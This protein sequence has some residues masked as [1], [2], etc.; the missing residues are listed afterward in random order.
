MVLSCTKKEPIYGNQP[1]S[2]AYFSIWGEGVS[3]PQA[4]K[5]LSPQVNPY[6][7]SFLPLAKQAL[8]KR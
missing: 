4:T 5:T 2:E 7:V 6:L 3:P 1:W 8:K